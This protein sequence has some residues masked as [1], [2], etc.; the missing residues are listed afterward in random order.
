MK[1]FHE[2]D[3]LWGQAEVSEGGVSSSMSWDGNKNVVELTPPQ[4]QGYLFLA[5]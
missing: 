4:V 3:G 2:K 1:L 5:E